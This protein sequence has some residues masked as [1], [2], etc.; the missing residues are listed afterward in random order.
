MKDMISNLPDSILHYILS[1]LPTKDAIQTSILA[2]RW[3]YLWTGLSVFDFRKYLSITFIN[4]RQ[5]SVD[6]V[7]D[8]VDR[9]IYHSN[10]VRRLSVMIDPVWAMVPG[11]SIDADKVN[12]LISTAMKHNIEELKLFLPVRPPFNLSNC[13]SASKSLNKL[14]LHLGCVLDVS[15]GIHFPSL[16]TLKLSF[17][18]F[19]NEKSAQQL[20]SGCP[21][22]QKLSLCN[23]SWDNIEQINIKFPTLKTLTIS[24]AC[25]S[26]GHLLNSTVTI[27][28]ANLLYFS[29]KSHVTIELVFVNLDSI[30]DA[31]IDVPAPSESLIKLLSGLGNIKSLRLSNDMVECFSYDFHLLPMFN[32]LTHLNVDLGNFM[33]TEEAI[34]DILQKTPKLEVLNIPMG[35]YPDICLDGEDW[36][37]NSV[38]SCFKNSLKLFSISNFDGG[39]AE[40]QLLKFLLENATVLSEIRIFCSKIL[41]ADLKKQAEISN[42]LQPVGLGSCVIKLYQE[43]AMEKIVGDKQI[44]YTEKYLLLAGLQDY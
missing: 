41:S 7:F 24:G 42:Q 11:F 14:V 19:A 9:L 44:T 40:I 38:P 29:Y 21:V 31:H 1:L 8:Q 35:F 22:L 27:D 43:S 39:E 32:N 10:Y 30:V 33:F 3:K 28:V 4:Q 18:T 37:L 23:C 36:I 17:V 20:F 6:C 16:K 2:K 25:S 34:M 12:S 13:F 5:K 26:R 15:R